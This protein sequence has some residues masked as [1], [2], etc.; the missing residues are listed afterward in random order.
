M[1]KFRVL[2]KSS[3]RLCSVHCINFT[4][5]EQA[6]RADVE[7]GTPI[8]H[9]VDISQISAYISYTDGIETILQWIEAENAALIENTGI[10]DYKSKEIYKGDILF[11]P[12]W[13]LVG[14]NPYAI[15]KW[16]ENFKI[17]TSDETCTYVDC[18]IVES[19]NRV[20][21]SLRDCID[22]IHTD[23][24]VVGNIYDNP[25]LLELG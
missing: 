24:Y 8:Y 16:Q 7:H 14:K 13:E 15:V 17:E 22:R 10:N 3:N 20:Q 9:D 6:G 12:L 5:P 1:S 4:H 19:L 18:F 25:D 11:I 23:S 2:V 21:M